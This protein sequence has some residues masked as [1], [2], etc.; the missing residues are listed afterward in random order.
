MKKFILIMVLFL[1]GIVSYSQNSSTYDKY[2]DFDDTGFLFT[3][4]STDVLTTTDTTWTYTIQKKIRSDVK[5]IVEMLIDS[6]GGT[7]NNVVIN[8]QNM[9]FSTSTYAT[10][11]T[12]TWDGANDATDGERISFS[13]SSQSFAITA[14]GLD[15]ISGVIALDTLTL[16]SLTDT[17]GLSGY[18][19]DSI[20]TAM[21]PQ[22]GTF[23]A[24]IKPTTFAIAVT[25]SNQ[26]NMG[27]YWR[28]TITG[29][30]N[31]LLAAIR[32]LN[33]KFLE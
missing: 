28:L 29:A 7:A 20:V 18:P 21:P 2:L 5:C 1:I 11:A 25:E 8:L 16:L 13:P 30:D 17:T 10:V 9:H 32:W 24:T 14:A 4:A 19:A 22:A 27:E 31:T 6:T 15:S 12:T 3:G 33:F 26:I 23:T